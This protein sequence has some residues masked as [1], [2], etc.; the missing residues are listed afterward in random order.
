MSHSAEEILTESLAA[1]FEAA[2]EI[3]PSEACQGPD[4]ESDDLNIAEEPGRCLRNHLGS[5]LPRD[6][7]FRSIVGDYRTVT[8]ATLLAPSDVLKR[9]R[10][11]FVL[12][13]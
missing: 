5:P 13:Y 8:R 6:H 3:R 9:P 7:C 4:G 11:R 1:S 12:S 10:S 2:Y